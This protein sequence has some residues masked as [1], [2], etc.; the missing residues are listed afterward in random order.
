MLHP[1]IT[2]QDNEKWH[3]IINTQSAK[4]LN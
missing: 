2:M 3:S 1:Q 4:P